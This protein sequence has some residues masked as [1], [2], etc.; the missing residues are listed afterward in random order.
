MTK[1]FKK[2]SQNPEEICF[3]RAIAAS[4][5]DLDTRLIF[6]DW[7]EENERTEICPQCKGKGWIVRQDR[8]TKSDDGKTVC[9]DCMGKRTTENGFVQRAELIRVQCELAR[10]FPTTK[11]KAL[12]S[13]D[14]YARWRS[15]G[16]RERELI[17]IVSTAVA[18]EIG[19]GPLGFVHPEKKTIGLYVSK[20]QSPSAVDVST[21]WLELRRG[22]PETVSCGIRDWIDFGPD[23]VSRCPILRVEIEDREPVIQVNGFRWWG[24]SDGPI[25]REWLRDADDVPGFIF[26]R[27]A[28]RPDGMVGGNRRIYLLYESR[29]AAMKALSIASL[30]WAREESKRRR[31]KDRKG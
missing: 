4:P 29:E 18:E 16:E 3:V 31:V 30:E 24:D 21:M 26:D 9:R 8:S 20:V 27:M 1:Q 17:S 11:P 14:R 23:V 13:E 22:F 25:T 19:I 12:G 28:S 10:H 5:E 2:D 6:A 15:L 7:L